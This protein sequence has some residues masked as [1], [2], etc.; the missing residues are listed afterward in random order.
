MKSIEQR[1]NLI[2]SRI[3]NA[4]ELFSSIWVTS[5]LLGKLFCIRV[6]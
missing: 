6:H 3:S 2:F 4:F 5:F 1:L